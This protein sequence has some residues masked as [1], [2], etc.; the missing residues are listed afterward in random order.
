MKVRDSSRHES[1]P[2][3]WAP[4]DGF[5]RNTLTVL[6]S[7]LTGI[8]FGLLLNAGMLLRGRLG[9]KHGLLWGCAGFAVISL[10]PALGLP[11]QLPGVPAENLLGRQTWWVGTALA[12]AFGLASFALSPR[13]WVRALG[14]VVLV[15]P[16]LIGPPR[17]MILGQS[18]VAHL[19]Q[20]FIVASLLSMLT[21]WLVLGAVSSYLQNKLVARARGEV[22]ATNSI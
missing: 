18:P 1:A 19:E 5:E 14:I 9:I 13:P 2:A 7:M 4:K 3:E 8:G 12:T 15:V 21:F 16:H 20:P 10:A 17:R 6:F 11:P 22:L